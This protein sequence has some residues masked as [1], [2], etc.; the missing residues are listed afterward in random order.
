MLTKSKSQDLIVHNAN[1]SPFSQRQCD[2]YINATEFCRAHGK[3]VNDFLNLSSTQEY[4]SFLNTTKAGIIKPTFTQKG[5]GG[6]T[7]VHP[8]LAIHLGQWV[9]VEMMD[10][11]SELVINWM[12]GKPNQAK[13][14]KDHQQDPLWQQA[15]LESKDM[16]RNL[17]DTLKKHGKTAVHHISLTNQAYRALRGKDAKG[18]RLELGLPENANLR[19]HLT[20]EELS[21]LAFGE[22]VA[23]SSIEKQAL[24][25]NA[26]S[27]SVAGRDLKDGVTAFR[28]LRRRLIG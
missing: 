28:D 4:I 19:D 6:G 25:G 14:S 12:S 8:K 7:W 23:V 16:R 5:K 21:A 1:G 11:V 9:S 17:G 3:R 26:P 10:F 22:E 20:K 27:C 13:P 2:G 24:N 15:R 18:I